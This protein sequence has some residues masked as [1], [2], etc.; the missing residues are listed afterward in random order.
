MSASKEITKFLERYSENSR[1][2][3]L[4]AVFDADGTLWQADAG[5][6]LFEY[7][8]SRHL[9]PSA[10]AQ[11]DELQAVYDAILKS[12]DTRLAYE[13]VIKWNAGASLEE[14]ESW[15]AQ[16]W[17]RPETKGRCVPIDVTQSLVRALH[18][19]GFEV[20]VVSASNW[21]L[22]AHAVAPLGIPS[23]RVIAGRLDVYDGRLT[24]KWLY[25]L[26][27]RATKTKAIADIIGVW[28]KLV[29]GN[30]MGDYE[31]MLLAQELVLV[32]NTAKPG[33]PYYETEQDL[34]RHMTPTPSGAAWVLTAG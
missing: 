26:P 4:V 30:S 16:C 29:A 10:P 8:K 17:A 20:W 24:D 9:M 14:M 12:G 31:M 7:Q 34:A 23:E 15:V 27:Y 28:P 21:W 32:I 11:G 18:Q 13:S 1:T 2:E 6:E 25:P 19:R 33:D 3:R 5:D 22:V